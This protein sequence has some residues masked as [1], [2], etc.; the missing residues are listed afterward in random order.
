[1][2]VDMDKLNAFVGKF[3]NDLGAA[4]QGPAILV[5]EQLGLYKA[6]AEHGPLT[7]AGLAEKTGTKERYLRE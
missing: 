2:A 4:M 6:L 5:G 7:S 3:V 1:M